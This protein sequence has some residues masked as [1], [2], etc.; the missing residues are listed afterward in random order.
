MKY[1]FLSIAA[2]IMLLGCSADRSA[3]QSTATATENAQA[4]P[5]AQSQP[6][7][8]DIIAHSPLEV[9]IRAAEVTVAK[10]ASVCVPVTVANFNAIIGMQF[11]I[12][13][14]KQ[15]LNFQEA[16][17]YN[18]PKM[19]AANFGANRTSE[20]LLT[21][22]WLDEMLKGATL[23]DG[24]LLFEVCFVAKGNPGQ[25]SAIQI[26]DQPTAIEII[27]S[28]DQVLNLKAVKG[29]VTIQ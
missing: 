5:A 22:L 26:T 25:S 7:S 15:L 29:K 13:W 21:T 9:V 16:K 2:G 10:G 3:D 1:F 4:L 14:D 8:A 11:T 6:V 27:N 17:N 23:K 28:R 24:D 19:S 12:Q 20:G 18:L